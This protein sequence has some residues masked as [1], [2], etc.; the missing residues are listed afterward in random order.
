MSDA[1]QVMLRSEMNTTHSRTHSVM[2]IVFAQ[3][4]H[5]LKIVGYFA[6]V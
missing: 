3:L 5:L 1:S 6:H 2:F 4:F